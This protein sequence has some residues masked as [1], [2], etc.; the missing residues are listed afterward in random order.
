M[1]YANVMLKRGREKWLQEGHPWVFRAA[2]QAAPEQVEPG[3]IVDVV[4]RAGRFV[5]R[6]YYNPHSSIPVRVLTR[7]EDEEID[8]NWIRERILQAVALRQ[9]DPG[10]TNAFRLVHSENDFLP[11]VIV[12]QY[13]DFLVVQFHTLGMDGFRG[14]IVDAL[15]EIIKPRG[16]YER[17][18]VGARLGEGLESE[19]VGVLAGDE[20]PKHVVIRENGAEFLC[21]IK[22]G[23]K[24]GFFLDQ[25]ENRLAVS[26]FCPDA[27]VLNCFSYSGG[28]SVFAARGGARFVESVDASEPAL[29][30]ARENLVRNGFDSESFP[31]IR[32]QVFDHLKACRSAGRSFDVVIVDPPAFAKSRGDLK[33]AQRAY[34]RLNEM[35]MQVLKPGGILVSASCSSA[36]DYDLFWDL[37][38]KAGAL[39]GRRVQV[40]KTHLQSIDHPGYIA[41]NEGRYF[42]CFFCRVV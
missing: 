40:I 27:E 19:P 3:A 29:S 11:G 41:F 23:Q 13:A 6:G 14:E 21:D 26:T 24:T 17:S 35:A 38:K 7:N 15:Q 42:K 1:A 32:A 37:I 34:F 22:G 5:A 31:C 28:F 16:I 12:D 30:L 4:D 25:R 36:V 33:R 8:S 2:V 39:A 10:E 18:D 20:P 9:F